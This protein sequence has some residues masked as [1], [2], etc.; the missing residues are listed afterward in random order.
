V[1]EE[2]A[3]MTCGELRRRL[4]PVLEGESEPEA[5]N[6]L[7]ACPHCRELAD[8]LIAIGR[9]GA[10]LPLQEPSRGLWGRILRAAE[11]EEL[12]ET[13]WAGQLAGRFGLFQPVAVNFSF[14]AT[15]VVILFAAAALVGYPG[16]NL[17]PVSEQAADR[18]AV[19]RTEL[20]LAPEYGDRY[21]QH[22]DRIEEAVRDE[23]LLPDTQLTLV[24]QSNLDTLDRYIHQCQAR[25]STYPN[26]EFTRDELNRLYQQK[27]TLLQATLDPDW[28]P[29]VR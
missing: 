27:T 7:N 16:L 19:A 17:S 20:A 18:I 8:E 25:L 14:A 28:Q 21:A 6:H 2:S 29:S 3:M 1:T 11:A 26:D 22:L 4:G 5:L 23:V 12:I 15:L 10:H 24:A 9:A 13:S